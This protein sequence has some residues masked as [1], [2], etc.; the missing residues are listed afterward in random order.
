MRVRQVIGVRFIIDSDELSAVNNLHISG[1]LRLWE[2]TR[3]ISR[4]DHL[5]A[6]LT[7]ISWLVGHD[8]VG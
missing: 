7:N 3:T 5:E 8:L 2:L 4:V 1:R 6:F